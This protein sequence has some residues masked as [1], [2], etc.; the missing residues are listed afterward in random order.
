MADTIADLDERLLK[1]RDAYYAA[2]DGGKLDL[3]DLAYGTLDALLDQR[4]HAKHDR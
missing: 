1:A 4:L 2:M 3:A